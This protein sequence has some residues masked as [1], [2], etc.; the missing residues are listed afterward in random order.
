MKHRMEFSH[1]FSCLYINKQLQSRCT[2][3]NDNKGHLFYSTFL[4][5]PS[6]KRQNLQEMSFNTFENSP[7]VIDACFRHLFYGLTETF[8]FLSDSREW[9]NSRTKN[10]DPG[11]R[12]QLTAGA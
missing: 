11:Q 3:Y 1:S 7:V 10:N 5:V 8:F 4:A 2:L 12:L 9:V 6:G